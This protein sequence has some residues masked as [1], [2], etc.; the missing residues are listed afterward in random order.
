[1]RD[2]PKFVIQNL[3]RRKL[4]SWLTVIGIIVGVLAIVS[5]MSL[6]QGLKDNITKE[7]DKLGAQKITITSKAS[8]LGSQGNIGLSE[9][10]IRELQKI[11]ELQDV[12]G[13]INSGL[14]IKYNNVELFFTVSGYDPA[15]MDKIFIQNNI[16]LLKGRFPESPKAKEIVVGYELYGNPDNV[17][18][19]K[20]DVG[21]TLEINSDN[22]TVVGI[23]KDTGSSQTNKNCYM[24][25]ET[26]RKITSAEDNSVDTIYAIVKSD[27]NLD[28]VGK[29]IETRLEKS[30]G[31]K[32]FTVTTPTQANKD[33]QDMLKIVSIVVIGI[34][35]ISLL[36]GGIGIMNSMYT[37]VLERRKEIG[38]MKAIGA[39]RKDIL[40]MFL[41]EAGLIGLIGGILGTI[42]G[43]LLALAVNFVGN[44]LGAQLS[45]AFNF[46]IVLIALGFSFLIGI[47]SGLLPAYRAS[48]QEAVDAL[49]EE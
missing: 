23:I 39:K 47:I 48:K 43:F 38:V 36:V 27:Q 46:Q 28:I 32:D 7:F 30:R 3:R 14:A 13:T 42:G 6:S 8:S 17:F 2:L 10:D 11:S 37:S 4:R 18:K 9:D 1:M 44:Q 16:E 22:Y 40:N 19:K 29:K 33:R 41:L 15:L 24:P 25:L 34:A 26:L 21:T 45:I 31:S 49:H 5:L 20:V 12:I 35:S